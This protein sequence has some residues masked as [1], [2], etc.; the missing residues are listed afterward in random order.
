[1]SYNVYRA[2]WICVPSFQFPKETVSRPRWHLPNITK[3]GGS[4]VY[5]KWIQSTGVWS[6]FTFDGCSMNR[7]QVKLQGKMQRS[8]KFLDGYWN[9]KQASN[10]LMA[11]GPIAT[12]APLGRCDWLPG[13]RLSTVWL[14]FST[15]M[16][17]SQNNMKTA[18]QLQTWTLD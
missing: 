2:G 1:M 13:C 12:W 3:G 4:G 7:D 15:N 5:G 9:C 8:L 16:Q 14:S 6:G 10:C 18:C 17:G 11:I